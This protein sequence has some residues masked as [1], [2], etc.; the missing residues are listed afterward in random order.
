[1]NWTI[2]RRLRPIYLP[3]WTSSHNNL[4]IIISNNTTRKRPT[5]FIPMKFT[6]IKRERTW[7][8]IR[9]SFWNI[10]NN[11]Y[12]KLKIMVG[13]RII[14]RLKMPALKDIF[15]NL[16]SEM[17]R[18]CIT[19]GPKWEFKIQRDSNRNFWGISKRNRLNYLQLTI[20]NN[21]RL[22]KKIR[23]NKLF[24]II[25]S[26]RTRKAQK[27]KSLNLNSNLIRTF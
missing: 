4:C 9:P 21:W 5:K 3:P 26:M 6:R 12:K 13:R 24:R 17:Q 23:I 1:M 19:L 2:Y 7:K 18:R 11:S 16:C 8:R 14:M 10:K 22:F 27:D 15:G 20:L 25:K